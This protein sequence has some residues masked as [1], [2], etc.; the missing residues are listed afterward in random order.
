MKTII[1]LP[2]FLLSSIVQAAVIKHNAI[3]PTFKEFSFLEVCEKLGSKNNELMEAKSIHEIDC[4][5][6]IFAAVDFCKTIEK[7][8][9]TLTRAIVDNKTKTVNCE[10][11][12]SVMLSISCDARDA[13]YCLDPKKGC[14]ELKDMY[15][16]KLEMAH[17]SFIEIKDEKSINCYFA[18]ALN[19]DLTEIY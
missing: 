19:D 17:Y 14:E 11:S 3:K 13:K 1:F 10:H 4:M 12:S 18:K 8:D 9:S 2:L 6:K 15:A 7:N 16:V 5:G